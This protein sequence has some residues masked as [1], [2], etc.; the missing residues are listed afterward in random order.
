MKAPPQT[1]KPRHRGGMWGYY[2]KY[3]E[4][5]LTSVRL[6]LWLGLLIIALV[7]ILNP[8]MQEDHVNYLIV[9][10]SCLGLLMT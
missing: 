8:Y 6:Y 2:Q 7:I 9:L 3:I 10:F 4:P 5:L 1:K